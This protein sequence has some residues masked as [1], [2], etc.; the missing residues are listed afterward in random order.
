[1]DATKG[2]ASDQEAG[3]PPLSESI[4]AI[5]V[6]D[7]SILGCSLFSTADGTLKIGTDISM[8]GEDVVEQFLSF[9]QPTT[10]LVSRRV[11]ES[12]VAFIEKHAE[13]SDKEIGFR[14]AS[15]SDFSHTLACEELSSLDTSS[16][17]VDSQYVECSIQAL[18]ECNRQESQCM[19]LV[20]C[21]SSIDLDNITSVSVHPFSIQYPDE[22]SDQT[23]WAAQVLFSNTY[24]DGG[25]SYLRLTVPARDICLM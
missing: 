20:H 3:L 14:L 11:P 9:A 17:N 18:Q 5:D 13:K 1:M 12:I 23:S 15:P 24:T 16:V 4:L 21:S 22:C 7:R 2:A 25:H 19:K 6:K 10:I 8:A